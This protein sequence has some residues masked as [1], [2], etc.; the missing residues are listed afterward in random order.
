VSQPPSFELSV[1][2]NQYLPEGQQVIDAVISVSTAGRRRGPAPSAAQVIMID[3][4]TSMTGSKISEARQ[5][6]GVA[7]DMLNDDVAFA[8]VA[9]TETARMVYPSSPAMVPSSPRTRE[10]ARTAIRK[11]MANGGTAIGTWLELANTLLARQDAEIKHAILLTDGH[12]EHQQPHELAATLHR[13]RDRFVCDSR[14]VGK[15]WVAEPLLAIAE[16]LHGSAKGL[17]DVRQLSDEFRAMAEAFM[18]TAVANVALRVWH[19]RGARVRF[20][21]E[22]HPHAID[23]TDRRTPVSD[24]AGDYPIGSWGAETRDYHLSV[25]LPPGNEVGDDVLAA[26]VHVMAASEE[27]ANGLVPAVWTDDPTLST[28]FDQRVAHYTG[29]VELGRAVQDGL[30]A[31]R[32]GREDEAAMKLGRAA[33]LALDSERHDTMRVLGKVVDVVDAAAAQ[34]RIRADM[35]QV[36]KEMLELESRVTVRWRKGS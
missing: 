16:A 24:L 11:L 20:L 19:P 5:A 1:Y 25:E 27:L 13:C 26:R 9:G 14:G 34:V 15:D 32:E 18:S 12:N 22:V 23:L 2:H 30:A 8:V 31:L 3:C 35:E 33:Q 6:T 36:D 10:D 29:Q 28:K 7:V 17:P 4:S 21:K